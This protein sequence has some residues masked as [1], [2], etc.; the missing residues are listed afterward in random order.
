MEKNNNITV[1]RVPTNR[2]LDLDEKEEPEPGALDLYA[3]D[4]L[5]VRKRLVDIS[6][7]R[8][9]DSTVGKKKRKKKASDMIPDLAKGFKDAFSR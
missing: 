6:F 3:S 7:S 1:D 2:L 8:R 5:I 4:R 9:A